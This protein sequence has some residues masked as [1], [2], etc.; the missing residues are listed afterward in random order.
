M[1]HLFSLI[2]SPWL[3]LQPRSKLACPRQSTCDRVIHLFASSSGYRTTSVSVTGHVGVFIVI[4][5]FKGRQVG[6]EDW[7]GYDSVGTHS[8]SSNEGRATQSIV[9]KDGCSSSWRRRPPCMG[10]TCKTP[11]RFFMAATE[12][13]SSILED[14][15]CIDTGIFQ[16]RYLVHELVFAC[17]PPPPLRPPDQPHHPDSGRLVC[18]SRSGSLRAGTPPSHHDRGVGIPSVL[19]LI[20]ARDAV[21]GLRRFRRENK[22]ACAV[23]GPLAT[24]LGPQQP[25]SSSPT[26]DRGE[27][28]GANHATEKKEVL[29]GRCI[30]SIGPQSHSAVRQRTGSRLSRGTDPQRRRIQRGRQTVPTE[31]L[32]TGDHLRAQ[33]VRRGSFTTDQA[34]RGI[35]CADQTPVA[36]EEFRRQTADSPGSRAR[37]LSS[38]QCV[39]TAQSTGALPGAMVPVGPN[40][41]RRFPLTVRF[42]E[43]GQSRQPL[44]WAHRQYCSGRIN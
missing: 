4:L 25:F 30:V 28:P 1:I 35:S 32:F 5:T 34:C 31:I 37:C 22:C 41:S 38:V 42:W 13:E 44:L 24:S 7:V 29:D 21:L 36:C 9:L 8:G 16:C 6:H 15:R 14:D 40:A 23:V 26:Y 27:T 18:R 20:G 43:L 19:A 2:V 10:E 33:P 17:S 12:G 3:P 11:L 39:R